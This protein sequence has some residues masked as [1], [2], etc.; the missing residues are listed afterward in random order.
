MSSN[1]R[2]IDRLFLYTVATL[3]IFGF[4]IFLSASLGL[5]TQ[6]GA[7]FATVATKQ[8]ISLAIGVGAFI[9]FSRLKYSYLRKFALFMLLERSPSTSSS[10][11]PN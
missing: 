5:L 4:V 6:N 11:C 10:S 8:A 1:R 7:S 9:I 2:K 3:T